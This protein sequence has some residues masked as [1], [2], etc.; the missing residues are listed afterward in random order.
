MDDE[1]GPHSS[2]QRTQS[3]GVGEVAVF[4]IH[5]MDVAQRRQGTLQLEA[6]LAIFAGEQDFQEATPSKA[7]LPYST[8]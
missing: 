2:H 7:C 1:V 5:C 6:E 8:R 3:V 4:D